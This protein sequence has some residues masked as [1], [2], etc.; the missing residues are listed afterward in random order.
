ML[1][2]TLLLGLAAFICTIGAALG[3]CPDWV[4]TLLLCVIVLLQSLPLGR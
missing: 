4:P 2:V 3:K 1:T